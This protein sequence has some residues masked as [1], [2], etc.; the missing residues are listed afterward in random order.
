MVDTVVVIEATTTSLAL[1]LTVVGLMVVPIS[2]GSACVL[3]FGNEILHNILLN[4]NNKY[5]KQ[6]QKD[7]Q[8]IKS[9]VMLYRNCL[10]GNLIDIKGYESVY[11]FINKY[12]D[13]KKNES[14][15]I[16]MNIK[17]KLN[18]FSNNNLNF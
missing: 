16:H 8:Y 6:Y 5:K 3:S 11:H 18:L 7:Q 14:F 1:S 10:R 4:K 13:G 17:L 2:A 15:F 12:V 9:F